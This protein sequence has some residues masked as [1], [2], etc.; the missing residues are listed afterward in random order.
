MASL[1][2]Q[3]DTERS[4]LGETIDRERTQAAAAE[5]RGDRLDQA[6]AAERSRADQLEGRAIKAEETAQAWAR[7]DAARKAKPLL[8]RLRDAW[9]GD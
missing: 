7:A 5:A 2:E 3:H 6:L 8:S 1:K 9:R 4:W